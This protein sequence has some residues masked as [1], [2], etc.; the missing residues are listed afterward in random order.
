MIP[1]SARRAESLRCYFCAVLW[2]IRHTCF[3]QHLKISETCFTGEISCVDRL[4]SKRQIL[5]GINFIYKL[6]FG[7]MRNDYALAIE[8]PKT[9]FAF[10]APCFIKNITINSSQSTFYAS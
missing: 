2:H 3:I 10:G 9:A 5:A 7:T 6:K 1:I 4:A 8:Q